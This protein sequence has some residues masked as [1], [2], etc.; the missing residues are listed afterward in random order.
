MGEVI[1]IRDF[2]QARQKEKRRR[3]LA[4]ALGV[5]R[6]ALEVACL[7]YREA[8]ASE[9]AARARKVKLLKDVVSYAEQRL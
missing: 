1:Y 3:E 5:L 2:I 6:E 4:E 9:K 7:G 8:P